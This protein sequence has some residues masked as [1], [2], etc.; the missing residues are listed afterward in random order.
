MTN[1]NSGQVSRGSSWGMGSVL[2]QAG[3]S[4]GQSKSGANWSN[5]SKAVSE[6]YNA[7]SE[8]SKSPS[9]TEK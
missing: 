4:T 7:G 1:A 9:R 2:R 3:G 5:V 6:R 8:R